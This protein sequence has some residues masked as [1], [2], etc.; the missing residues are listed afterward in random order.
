LRERRAGEEDTEDTNVLNAES[1]LNPS[2][3]FYSTYADSPD[4]DGSY[5]EVHFSAG[6]V[7]ISGDA[8]QYT[9]IGP[10]FV[11]Q[12]DAGTTVTAVVTKSEECSD[13][14]VV[15]S[16]S[17]NPAPF[18]WDSSENRVVFG[19]DCDR[20]MIWSTDGASHATPCSTL[21]ENQWD[22]RLTPSTAHFT[23]ANCGTITGATSH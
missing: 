23:D 20:K 16:T 5:N 2:S 18:H 6:R 21:G 1:W 14:Y 13:H 11:R 8:S 4:N 10:R 9:S 7:S 12:I 17:D 15:F 3:G 19:F 22:V